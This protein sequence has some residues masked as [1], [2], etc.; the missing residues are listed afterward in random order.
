MLLKSMK[1]R[2][3]G[4]DLNYAPSWKCTTK[5]IFMSSS[6]TKDKRPGFTVCQDHILFS[7]CQFNSKLF[8]S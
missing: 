2:E 7:K 4:Q 6:K 3:A 8:L 5:A 1:V